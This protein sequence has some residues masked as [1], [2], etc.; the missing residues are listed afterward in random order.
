MA[1]SE[2]YKQGSATGDLRTGRGY[3]KAQKTPSFGTGVGSERSMGSSDSGIY[4]EPPPEYEEDDEYYLNGG[5]TQDE[6]DG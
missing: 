3:G 6:R 5:H 1:S 4:A 2:Y